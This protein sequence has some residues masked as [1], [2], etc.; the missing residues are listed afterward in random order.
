MAKAAAKRN[1][2]KNKS[3]KSKV[4]PF[5]VYWEK[6]NYFILFA[7]IAVLILGYIFMSMGPWNSFTS[8]DISPV[9][10]IIGYVVILPLAIL[11]KKRN[12]GSTP[13]SEAQT[14]VKK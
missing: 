5:N 8:L 4:A 6:T 11:Y 9:L 3:A 1:A 14:P 13:E 7:G 10:L 12:G 2:R